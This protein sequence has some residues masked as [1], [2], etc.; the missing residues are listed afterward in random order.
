MSKGILTPNIKIL[1]QQMQ[2]TDNQRLHSLK[3]LITMFSILNALNRTT[4]R[5]EESDNILLFGDS[6]F[7]ADR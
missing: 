3:V 6:E 2:P 1:I 5:T 7:L 4:L